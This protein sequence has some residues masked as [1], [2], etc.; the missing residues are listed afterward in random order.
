MGLVPT[1]AAPPPFNVLFPW[2]LTQRYEALDTPIKTYSCSA[3]GRELTGVSRDG[4]RVAFSSYLGVSGTS[5]FGFSTIAQQ[6][7]HLPGVLVGTNAYDASRGIPESHVSSRGVKIADVTDGLSNTLLVG[8]R[9]P[10][11]TMD[12]GW[13]FAGAGQ[14]ETGSCDVILGVREI[15]LQTSGFPCDLCPSNGVGPAQDGYHFS[16]GSLKDPCAQFHFWSLHKGGANFLFADG[17][18]HFIS[19]EGDGI[20]PALASRSGGEVVTLP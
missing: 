11:Q 1:N 2:D 3:D 5:L 17:S 15:N 4:L 18:V 8:E 13:W 7:Q 14:N 10:D 12:F 19:Y 6:S 20:L 9:P 16:N